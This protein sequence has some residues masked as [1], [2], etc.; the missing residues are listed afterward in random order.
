MKIGLMGGSFDPIH[1][2]HTSIV[3]KAIELFGLD[4]FYFI[5]TGQNPWKDQQNV[6]D[7]HR[8]RMIEIAIKKIN[9]D[10]YIGIEKY[11][12]EHN[13][14]K[15]YTYKTLEHLI[16]ENPENE[17]YYFIGMDQAEKFEYWKE[18]KR[19]SRM[20]QLVCFNRGG[21]ANDSKNIKK[22]HF[23][24]M[25]NNG[26]EASSTEIREGKLSLLDK[27]VLRYISKH[28]LYLETM[29]RPRMK[30]KRYLHTLSVAS[31]AAKIAESNGLNSQQAYIAGIMHDVAKETD[32]DLALELMNKYYPD[33][34][35]KPEPVWHQW[36]S[37]YVSK[38]EFL[39]DDE[40]ILKAIEDHT[41]AS[42]TI[43]KIGMC[44]YVADKL[45]PLRGYDSSEDI[46]LCKKNIVE[47]FKKSLISF[48]EF[49]KKKGRHIDPCFFDVY[50][51]FVKGDLNG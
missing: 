28:G 5:P 3:E 21:Y 36:L 44:L 23:I 34:V 33:F 16:K 43:S 13:E 9:S 26:I 10:K 4:Q 37:A 20:V 17:Y 19:I 35:D 1:L 41:T 14:E 46:E 27:D 6:A 22:Y 31:L 24:K 39:I 32:Y 18:A 49:S 45:D 47:G 42:P 12:I 38:N 48:Y 2:G 40:V 30:K 11:E 7:E 8:I 29:I 51:Q 50:N 25:E 15:N